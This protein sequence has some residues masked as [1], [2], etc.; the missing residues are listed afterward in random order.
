MVRSRCPKHQLRQRK[1]ESS[2]QLE[3]LEEELIHG[4]S[5]DYQAPDKGWPT[6]SHDTS[7]DGNDFLSDDVFD[8]QDR[9]NGQGGSSLCLFHSLVSTNLSMACKIGTTVIDLGKTP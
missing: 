7:N 5:K 2:I 8:G 6:S 4:D 1:E 3:R 9:Q